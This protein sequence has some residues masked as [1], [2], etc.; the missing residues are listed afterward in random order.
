MAIFVGELRRE[1]IAAYVYVQLNP[2][3]ERMCYS[4]GSKRTDLAGV[5]RP[6]VGLMIS[7]E[8]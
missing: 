3:P 1:G 2:V 4:A 6:Q 5:L 7:L 8:Y